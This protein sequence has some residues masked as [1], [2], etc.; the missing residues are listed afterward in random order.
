MVDILV[1][2]IVLVIMKTFHYSDGVFVDSDVV[3]K[4][5]QGHGSRLVASLHEVQEVWN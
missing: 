1:M 3:A 5:K 4:E 2:I